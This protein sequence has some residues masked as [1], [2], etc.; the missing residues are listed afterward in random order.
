MTTSFSQIIDAFVSVLSA[1]VA[2]SASISRSRTSVISEDETSAINVTWE[3]S[4]PERSTI[5]GAPIDW[6]SRIV[7]ECY[8]R[9]ETQTGD[10]AID[11]LLLAVYERLANNRTL[12]GLVDDIGE[13]LIE[14]WFD[15]QETR[16]GGVR[17]TYLVEH[18]TESFNLE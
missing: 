11:P 12:S 8:A 15:A 7:V 2:V 17:L 14:P 6:V 5:A 3:G 9:S 18:S 10:I 1:S 16:T 4:K 13:P